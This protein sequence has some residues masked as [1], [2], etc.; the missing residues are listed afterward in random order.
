GLPL[1]WLDRIYPRVEGNW[2]YFVG[3]FLYFYFS[4][5]SVVIDCVNPLF[6]DK[7]SGVIGVI[8]IIISGV[9]GFHGF[10]NIEGDGFTSDS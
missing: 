2:L 7:L 5:F 10:P 6:L 9:F 8:Q 4:P 1:E 3:I